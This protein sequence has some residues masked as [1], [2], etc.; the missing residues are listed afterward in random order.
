MLIA[1]RFPRPQPLSQGLYPLH[2]PSSTQASHCSNVTANRP[3][4]NGWANVTLCLGASVEARF[5]PSSSDPITKLPAGT[6]IISGHFSHSL[7]S[8]FCFSEASAEPERTLTPMLPSFVLERSF[9]ISGKDCDAVDAAK[10]L[11]NS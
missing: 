2:P 6:T 7:K 4:A 9:L 3:T 1:G 5:G 11:F 10:L 8:A